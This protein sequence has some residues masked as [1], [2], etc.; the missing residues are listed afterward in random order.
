M[1]LFIPRPHL[2]VVLVDHNPP[3][4]VGPL[5]YIWTILLFIQLSRPCLQHPWRDHFQ[6]STSVLGTKRIMEIHV[7]M[8]CSK[9]EDD[10]DD[11]GNHSIT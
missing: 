8:I 2:Q 9:Y 1:I 11:F 7:G 10:F 5:K 4:Q 6:P 3:L